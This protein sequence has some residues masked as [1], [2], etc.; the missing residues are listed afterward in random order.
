MSR[1]VRRAGL[2]LGVGFSMLFDGIVLHQLLQ[3]H[4]MASHV[5]SAQS[6][7]G[8]EFNTFWDGI[9]HA[10]GWVVLAAGVFLLWKSIRSKQ[11]F[12]S[13]KL[14]VSY[15]ILGFGL[16]NI[17]ENILNH[18]VLQIHHVRENVPNVFSYDLGFLIVMGFGISAL[19]AYLLSRTKKQIRAEMAT[20]QR[21]TRVA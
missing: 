21:L 7:E 20:V 5:Q 19:G 1:T 3:W 13:G 6:V 10:G 12:F 16:F 4:H 14:L 8:L 17:V 9:F 2:T 15:I 18:F 11:S